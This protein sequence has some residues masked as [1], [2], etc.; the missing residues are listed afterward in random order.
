MILG[1]PIG[2]QVGA[3]D[4]KP[5]ATDCDLGATR[6]TSWA[7]PVS[8]WPSGFGPLPA[9]SEREGD[10]GPAG[11]AIAAPLCEL[12]Q[13]CLL[14]EAQLQ[15]VALTPPSHPF[16]EPSQLFVFSQCFERVVV[17]SEFFFTRN[18]LVDRSVA[19]ET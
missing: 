11:Y 18:E 16:D 1:P 19:I 5:S 3:S 10:Q 9:R 8:R 13:G 6:A 4:L 17:A 2:T 7:V 12:G 14:V 15:S